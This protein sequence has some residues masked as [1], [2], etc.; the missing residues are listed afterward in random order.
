[1]AARPNGALPAQGGALNME[2]Y[3]PPRRA[4]PSLLPFKQ[5]ATGAMTGSKGPTTQPWI[6]FR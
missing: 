5:A 6:S 2:V 4:P 1:M 3:R